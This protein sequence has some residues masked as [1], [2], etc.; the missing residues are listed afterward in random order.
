[1]KTDYELGYQEGKLGF[2]TARYPHNFNYMSGFALGLRSFYRDLG[3]S[4]PIYDYLPHGANDINSD[5][6]GA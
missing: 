4:R 5:Y 1:M 6:Y 2:E 3:L